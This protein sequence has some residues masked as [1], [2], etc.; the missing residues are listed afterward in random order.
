[1]N[2]RFVLPVAVLFAAIAGCSGSVDVNGV[3]D[4]IKLTA[5]F[6]VPATD[7]GAKDAGSSAR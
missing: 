6:C 3:P 7:A 2:M 5:P 1:M 4:E